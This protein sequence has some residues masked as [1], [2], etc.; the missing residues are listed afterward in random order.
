MIVTRNA[1]P[2][3]PVGLGHRTEEDVQIILWRDSL[4]GRS[5]DDRISIDPSY[6]LAWLCVLGDVECT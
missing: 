5:Q 2:C 4:T 3:R 6:R 1:R